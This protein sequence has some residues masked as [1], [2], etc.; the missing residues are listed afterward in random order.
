MLELKTGDILREDAEALVNTVNCVGVMGRG[1]ALQFKNAYPDN[2]KEYEEACAAGDLIPGRMFVYET[3]KL[4]NPKYIINFPTKR[5]WR[6]KSKIE[7]I[8]NG[9]ENLVEIIKDRDIRSIALPPLGCGLGG[10]EWNEVKPLIE[11]ALS[12]L[13][14]VDIAV[15]EPAGVP[16]TKTMRHPEQMPN[17]TSGRAGL[18]VLINRYLEV[19]LDPY[20]T[21]LEVQ[22]LMYFMQE[23]GEPLKLRYSEGIYGPYADNLRH[24]LNAVEGY[25]VTG[26]ADGGENPDKRL[27]LMPNA[28]EKAIDKLRDTASTKAR[29]ERV[30]DLI[31]G[32]ESSFGLELLATVHWVCNHKQAHNLEETVECVYSWNRGKHKFSERQIGIAFDT[33]MAHG[34]IRC[35]QESIAC[36][37]C[38][39]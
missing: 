37:P 35:N 5:H 39:K 29:V 38:V 28:F 34:W 4:I 8:Q 18:I 10:L 24:V 15:F 14:G 9:L 13:D 22:K 11:S 31:N 17:M 16:D 3:G 7:D 30:M 20:I 2:F 27:E 36:L 12:E 19:L 1:I 33:L 32:F 25:Y 21:L 23:A 26:F 6:G